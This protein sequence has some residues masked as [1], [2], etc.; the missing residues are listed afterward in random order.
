MENDIMLIS[1]TDLCVLEAC[2]KERTNIYMLTAVKIENGKIWASDGHCL[3]GCTLTDADW[4]EY[5][6]TDSTTVNYTDCM[7]VPA[8]TLKKASGN[9]PNNKMVQVINN[10]NLQIDETHKH[11]ICTDLE[12]TQVIKVKHGDNQEWPNQQVIID[13]M[14][15]PE[16]MHPFLFSMEN[17]ETMLRVLKKKGCEG[18]DMIKFEVPGVPM[19]PARVTVDG[20]TGIIMPMAGN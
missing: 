11:L 7:I 8:D 9:I 14:P 15:K 12:T 16:S 13:N 17:L 10:I 4:N 1:K 18:L 19:Q 6:E 5:P 2:A 20:L 3:W